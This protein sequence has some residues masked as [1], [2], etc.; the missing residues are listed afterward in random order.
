MH[1]PARKPL[2]SALSVVVGSGRHPNP[3][4]PHAPVKEP[5]TTTPTMA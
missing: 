5:L 1:A 3:W 2:A 4:S